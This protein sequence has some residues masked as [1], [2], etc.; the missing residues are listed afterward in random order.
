MRQRSTTGWQ[1]TG[2]GME[3]NGRREAG[4]REKR[5]CSARNEGK[6]ARRMRWSTRTMERKKIRR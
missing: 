1:I 3:K 4:V 2:M 6:T 5:G